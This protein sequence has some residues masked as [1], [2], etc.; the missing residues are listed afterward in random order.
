MAKGYSISI[1]SD[2]KAFLTGVQKGIIDPLEDAAEVI[3]DIGSDGSRDLDKLERAMKQAQDETDDVQK[4]FSDLQKEI[5]ET[6]R[7]SRTD[8]ANPVKRSADEVGDQLDE[9]TSEAKQNAAEMFSSFDGSF[10]SIADAAQSTLGGLV[11]GLKGIPAIAAVAAG[12]AGLGLVSSEIVKQIDRAEELKQN[13]TDAY[14]AAAEEGRTFIDQAAIDAATLDILFD[15]ARR[16]AAFAEAARIGVDPNTYIRGLAGDAVALQ[17]SIDTARIRYQELV[18]EVNSARG[19][20]AYSPEVQA[21]GVLQERLEGI[22]E[23]HE[24]NQAAAEQ[25]QD[26]VTE[27]TREQQRETE[28]LRSVE[29]ERWDELGR[30]AADAAARPPVQIRTQLTAPDSESLRRATQGTFERRPVKVRAEF[31]SRDGKVVI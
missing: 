6:G 12:A 9:V 7:K 4:A 23:Q 21:V 2:T 15:T 29:Q 8:F 3:Q 27:S 1:A 16:E 20:E 5:R 18:D 30:R 11:G 22:Q 28:R 17:E 10:E 24:Q 19:G 25:Y 13:L 26:I 14:K 31:V